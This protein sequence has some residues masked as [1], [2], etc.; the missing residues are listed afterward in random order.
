M[1]KTVN[2]PVIVLDLYQ[3]QKAVHFKG[4]LSKAF[5]ALNLVRVPLLFC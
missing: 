5:Q 3:T 4:K 1:S 2:H